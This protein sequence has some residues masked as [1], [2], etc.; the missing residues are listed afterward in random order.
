MKRLLVMAGAFALVVA[1]C[2]S[3]GG[4]G[5]ATL[6]DPGSSAS[7]TIV[8]GSG[9]PSSDLTDEEALIAF[10]ACMRANGV[11]DFED[12][13]IESDG[14]VGF[15]FGPQGGGDERPFGDVDRETVRTAFEACSD[16]LG[17]LAIGPGGSDFDQGSFEDTFVEFA[18]CMRENG[19]Q[20]DD[21]D[22]S[23]FGPGQGGGPGDGNGGG[24]PFGD[25]DPNDPN[26]QAALSACQD[27]FGG[28]LPGGPGRG[29][30][31]GGQGSDGGA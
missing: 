26:V 17:G 6:D 12:P 2:S 1:A 8:D 7:D 16:E 25:I 14:S 28:V 31:V 21:P 20:M 18:A 23:N 30:G 29:P 19:V 11:E 4:N 27:I 3:A 22:F 10:A 24:G 9:T 5:V 13:T 15:G